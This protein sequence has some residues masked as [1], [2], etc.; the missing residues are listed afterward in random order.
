MHKTTLTLLGVIVTVISLHA[1][2]ALQVSS[3]TGRMER[4][5]VSSTIWA[6]NGTDS[7]KSALNADGRFRIKLSKGQWKLLLE[8]QDEF[9]N[10]HTILIDSM[11]LEEPR[12][13]DLGNIKPDL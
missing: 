1:F 5:P 9:K 7:V 11:K 8:N 12:D 13:I 6:V 10:T 3:V 4:A 2:K